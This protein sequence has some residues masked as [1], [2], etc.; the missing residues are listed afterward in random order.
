L[1]KESEGD[2]MLKSLGI[3]VGGVFVGAVAAEVFRRKYP[4]ALSKVS[5]K[6][7]DVASQAEVAFKKG[8][9]SATRSKK[10]VK[11]TA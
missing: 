11:S 7:R 9:E 1:E 10:T 4:K 2:A 8:Y 3:L 5:A 6:V